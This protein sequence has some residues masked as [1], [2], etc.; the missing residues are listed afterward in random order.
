MSPEAKIL[1]F[2]S[3]PRIDNMKHDKP[4]Q[5]LNSNLLYFEN[6]NGIDSKND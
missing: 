2:D 5:N 4:L 1:N 3:N 6:D